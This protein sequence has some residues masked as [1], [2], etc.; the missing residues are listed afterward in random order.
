MEHAGPPPLL[1]EWCD[2]KRG[3]RIDVEW[4]TPLKDVSEQYVSPPRSL[5]LLLTYVRR[6]GVADALL[7][8]RSR[9]SERGRNRKTAALIQGTVVEGPAG[10]GMEPGVR[11][12]AFAPNTAPDATR[13]VV[14]RAFVIQADAAA[15][16]LET[17]PDLPPSLM[18][19]VAW[20]PFS[21]RPI[22]EPAVKAALV[23]LCARLLRTAST[24]PVQSWSTG[25]RPAAGRHPSRPPQCSAWATTPNS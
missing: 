14:D 20:S 1:D 21:G 4:L 13:I 19:H 11:V 9:L 18:T 2:P 23:D 16:R 22:D 6:F 24:L 5:R 8:V 17:T 15:S 3:V 12:W 10:E 25:V 7:K